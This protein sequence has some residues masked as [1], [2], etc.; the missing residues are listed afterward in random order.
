VP[1][2]TARSIV[3]QGMISAAEVPGFFLLANLVP[4]GKDIN[5][6]PIFS[7]DRT[8]IRIEDVIAAEQ[9]RRPDVNHS[10]RE[11]NTGIV[12]VVQHG[13]APSPKLLERTDGIR[14]QWMSY[15]SIATGRRSVMTTSPR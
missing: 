7:A 3:Q 9:E 10:Q 1:Q 6:Q 15:W 11:F 13:R 4:V 14:Q 12:V 2:D 5:G 8:K